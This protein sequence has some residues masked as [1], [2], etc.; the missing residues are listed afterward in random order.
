MTIIKGKKTLKF[1]NS[2]KISA[3]RAI[4]AL[5]YRLCSS[6]FHDV[7]NQQKEKKGAFTDKKQKK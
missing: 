7:G 2:S 5:K 3:S 1:E 6:K 4:R